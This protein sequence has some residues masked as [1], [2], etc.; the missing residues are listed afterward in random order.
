MAAAADADVPARSTLSHTCS[1]GWFPRARRRDNYRQLNAA[2]T[3]S[4]YVIVSSG[5]ETRS[6]RRSLAV[7]MRYVARVNV[8]RRRRLTES[9]RRLSSHN[10]RAPDSCATLFKVAPEY[11]SVLLA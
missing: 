3:L 6:A 9:L 4:R 5:L 7:S 11:K 1:R 10:A 2:R 8:V